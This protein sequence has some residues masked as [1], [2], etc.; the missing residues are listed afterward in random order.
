MTNGIEDNKWHQG[1]LYSNSTHIDKGTLGQ[2]YIAFV[3]E[4]DK[5]TGGGCTKRLCVKDLK[6]IH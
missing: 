4:F 5:G 3:F 2:M 6:K 1:K